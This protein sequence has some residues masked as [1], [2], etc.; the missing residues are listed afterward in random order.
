MNPE[1]PPIEKPVLEAEKGT[2]AAKS[3]DKY[4]TVAAADSQWAHTGSQPRMINHSQRLSVY[5][6]AAPSHGAD[7][8]LVKVFKR[9]VRE[10]DVTFECTAIGRLMRIP[11]RTSTII[12]AEHTV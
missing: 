5:R 10:A 12:C 1:L 7:G 4:P 11:I 9:D 6:I 2:A 3:D 8:S